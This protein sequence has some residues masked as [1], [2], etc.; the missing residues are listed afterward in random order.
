[1]DWNTRL[2]CEEAHCI[3]SLKSTEEILN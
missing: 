1:M 3:F 2:L